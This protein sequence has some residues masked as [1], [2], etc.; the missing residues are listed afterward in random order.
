MDFEIYLR[1]TIKKR[2]PLN[3]GYKIFE[4]YTILGVGILDFYIVRGRERIVIDA[5]DKETLAMCDIGQVDYYAR[6]L[7]ATARIIYIAH[8]TQMSNGVKKEATHL[9]IKIIRTQ[10]RA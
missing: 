5:K 1:P 9:A 4:Q 10:Y 7:K 8:D 6:E 3:A 2:Y